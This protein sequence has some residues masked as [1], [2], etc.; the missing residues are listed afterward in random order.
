MGGKCARAQKTVLKIQAHI[1]DFDAQM[2]VPFQAILYTGS[3]H[4]VRWG[5]VV[6]VAPTNEKHGKGGPDRAFAK[7]V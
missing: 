1:E 4:L 3:A 2:A 5:G 7:T 6:F